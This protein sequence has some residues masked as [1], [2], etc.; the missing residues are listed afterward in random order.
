MVITEGLK[1][2]NIVWQWWSCPITASLSC[3]IT[4]AVFIS[5]PKVKNG[6]AREGDNEDTEQDAVALVELGW[7][8]EDLSGHDDEAVD[9]DLLDAVNGAP[10]S[11][12][13]VDGADPGDGNGISWIRAG[14][15][16]AGACYGNGRV[17]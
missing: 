1:V 17:W 10:L 8:V 14:G 16:K 3:G 6:G 2:T 9:K 4:F 12:A 13:S 7:G 15:N 11:V 5:Q